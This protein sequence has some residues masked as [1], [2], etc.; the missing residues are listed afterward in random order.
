MLPVSKDC[1]FGFV[2]TAR[3]AFHNKQG[4]RL[5]YLIFASRASVVA[6]EF[7]KKIS[8]DDQMSLF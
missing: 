8:T 3:R 5:Y 4:A 7:W 1:G 2:E 6:V